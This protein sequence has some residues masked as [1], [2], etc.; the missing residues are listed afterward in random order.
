MRRARSLFAVAALAAFG[1][2]AAGAEATADGGFIL[3]V[4]R[5]NPVTALSVSDL[6]RL[7]SGATKQWD[8][9]AVVH[10]GIIPSDAP[11]TQ[12]LASLLDM[13]T[14]ELLAR[15]QE[16]VFKGEL[17]RPV[18]LRSSTECVSFARAEAGALCVAGQSEAIP[19][20]AHAVVVKR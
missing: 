11:E 12:Y 15:L 2:L 4:N 6:R 18:T 1:V 13:S 20:E 14:R 19:P 7:I 5:D 16:Q 8:T 10:L 9:G 3:V 17:R